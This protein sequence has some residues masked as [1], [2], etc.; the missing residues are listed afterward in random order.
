MG[1]ELAVL[2]TNGAPNL[3]ATQRPILSG[4]YNRRRTRVGRNAF[5]APRVR[6]HVGFV[7]RDA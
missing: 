4:T 3:A 5:R 1:D 6:Q 7:P 2:P